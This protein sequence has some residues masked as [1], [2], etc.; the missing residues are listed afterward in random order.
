MNEEYLNDVRKQAQM[1]L[2]P[3]VSSEEYQEFKIKRLIKCGLL[4]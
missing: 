4:T 1:L 3:E 2:N